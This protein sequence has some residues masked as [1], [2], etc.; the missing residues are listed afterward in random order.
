MIYYSYVNYI[1]FRFSKLYFFCVKFKRNNHA[2]FPIDEK[3]PDRFV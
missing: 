2:N 1:L 3:H